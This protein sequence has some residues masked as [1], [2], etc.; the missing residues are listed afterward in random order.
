MINVLNGFSSLGKNI[1]L[2]FGTTTHKQMTRRREMTTYA[3]SCVDDANKIVT[4]IKE[5][6]TSEGENIK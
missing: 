3:Q 6:A 5:I 2:Y 4:G 1:T